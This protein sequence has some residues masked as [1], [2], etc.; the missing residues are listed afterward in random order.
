MNVTNPGGADSLQQI[1]HI[2]T[3]IAEFRQHQMDG[4]TADQQ[5]IILNQSFLLAHADLQRLQNV[6]ALDEKAMEE[7]TSRTD[8]TYLFW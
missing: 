2:Q 3:R 7:L 4:T 1:E 5:Q 6:C 8:S